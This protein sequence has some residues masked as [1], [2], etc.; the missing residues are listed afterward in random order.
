MSRKCKILIAI[1][2]VALIVIGAVGIPVLADETPTPT[3]PPILTR[4]AGVLDRVAEILNV[5]REALANAMQQ[6]A[7]ELRGQKPT[8]DD[9]YAKVAGI[10]GNITKEELADAIKQAA[11]ELRDAGITA[12][13]ENA[14]KNGVISDAEKKQIEDWYANKPAALDKLFDSRLFGGPKGWGWGRCFGGFGGMGGMRGFGRG[15]KNGPWLP[16][17]PTT[18]GTTNYFPN[19]TATSLTY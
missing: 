16:A 3:P 2:V 15:F 5:T 14:V 1:G 19:S 8:A 4:Q 10:L 7:Q 6:A 17:P 12:R 18:P 13:L 9:Y 11:T